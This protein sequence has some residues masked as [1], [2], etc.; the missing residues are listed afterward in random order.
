MTYEQFY[1]LCYLTVCRAG[2][3]RHQYRYR[4]GDQSRQVGWKSLVVFIALRGLTFSVHQVQA[5]QPAGQL[6][7]IADGLPASSCAS[8]KAQ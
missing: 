4:T 5:E 3:V 1:M 2:T 6:G 7:L 8:Y